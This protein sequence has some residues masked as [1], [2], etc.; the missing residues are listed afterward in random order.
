M[1]K[2]MNFLLTFKSVLLLFIYAIPGYLL[3]KT[4]LV[5]PHNIG[6]FAVVLLY[7]N[8]PCLSLY[9]FQKTEFTLE[10]FKEILDIESTSG[11]ERGLAEFLA[12][13]FTDFE[14][15]W[16]LKKEFV[17]LRPRSETSDF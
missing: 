16:I 10:L 6:A 7:V 4:K 3:I 12:K 11:T 13:K 5:K 8:Q 15:S 2:I 9:S 1:K 17:R 14:K